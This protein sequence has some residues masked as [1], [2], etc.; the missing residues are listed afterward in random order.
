[1]GVENYHVIEL[2]GEGSFGR[3][4]KGRRKHAGQ[5]V[6]M[7][8]IMKHGKSDKDIQNLRQE[9]EILRKLK[10]ENIIETH[11]SFGSPQEVCV[12]TES[13]QIV[14]CSEE[15]STGKVLYES[16][17]CV[18]IMLSRVVQAVKASIT[19]G[20][21]EVGDT[22]KQ[23]LDHAKTTGLIDQLCSCLAISG[24]SLVSGS[25]SFS[26]AASEA[27]RATWLPIEALENFALEENTCT[28]PLDA[29][30]YHSL[31]QLDTKD[32]DWRPLTGTASDK[33]VG[34]VARAFPIKRLLT[35]TV[36]K[37]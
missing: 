8:F 34:T 27:C 24:T 14:K 17:A 7:Q 26:H 35:Q 18:A 4:Y 31:A 21:S 20:H 13:A 36:C 22:L 2:V 11:D 32:C 37:P 23:V 5:T 3:V 16:T 19:A 6:A 9:I 33:I 15:D 28:F 25:L 1:M 29:H 30:R 10:H 12:V